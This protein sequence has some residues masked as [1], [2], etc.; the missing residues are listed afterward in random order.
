MEIIEAVYEKGVLKPLKPLKLKEGEKVI[1]KIDRE[2]LFEIIKRYQ[3]KF[4]FSEE[5][6]EEFLGERR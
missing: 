1:L 4:K 5:D 3:G 2:G 6:V